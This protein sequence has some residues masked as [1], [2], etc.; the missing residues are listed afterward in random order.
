MKQQQN[1]NTI[2]Q[3]SFAYKLTK[4]QNQNITIYIKMLFL[5]LAWPVNLTTQHTNQPQRIKTTHI[6][7]TEKQ[8]SKIIKYA[9]K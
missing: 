3:K 8:T 7:N 4:Q 1:Y 2:K 5:K 6:K 9:T